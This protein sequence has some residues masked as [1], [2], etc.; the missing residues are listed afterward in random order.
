MHTRSW[1]PTEAAAAEIRPT[2]GFEA[3]MMTDEIL[4]GSLQRLFSSCWA[5]T[6]ATTISA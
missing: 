6:P 5:G 3:D 2:H 1:E 4:Q